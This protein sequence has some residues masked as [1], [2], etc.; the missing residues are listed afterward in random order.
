MVRDLYTVWGHAIYTYSDPRCILLKEK[1]VSLFQIKS[2]NLKRNLNCIAVLNVFTG[3][4]CGKLRIIIRLCA[5]TLICILALFI[6]CSAYLP[7]S[8]TPLFA[9]SRI[10]GWCAHRLEEV[11]GCRQNYRDRH[12]SRWYTVRSIQK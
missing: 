12:I 10:V 1:Q 4:I 6:K 9:I 8:H 2:L 5:R 11:I 3:C 7:K